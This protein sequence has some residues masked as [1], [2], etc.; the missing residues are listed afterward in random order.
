M[1]QIDYKVD[2]QSARGMDCADKEGAGEG[3]L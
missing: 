2:H 1:S 3:A